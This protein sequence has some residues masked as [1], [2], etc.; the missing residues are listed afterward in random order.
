MNILMTTMGLQIGGAETHI[1]ELC[2]ALRKRGHTVTVAAADGVFRAE[3]EQNGVRCVILPLDRPAPA[4]MLSAFF[5]L[6]RL[7]RADHFDIVHA[8]ARLPA[9]LCR[10]ICRSVGIPLVTTAHFTFRLTPLRRH[11]SEWGAASLAVS[12][13]IKEYLIRNYGISPNRISLTVN[14]IDTE[15][16]HPSVRADA[17]L[18][19]FSLDPNCR[20]R[21]VYVSR[22]D[23]N[24]AQ[25]GEYLLD[26]AP[27]LL[28]AF[29]DL[30]ILIAGSGD[31]S[32]VFETRA[33]EINQSAGRAVVTLAG[34][35]T[36]IPQIVAAANVFL[37]VSRAALEAMAEEKPVV[38]A[39]PQGFLGIWDESKLDAAV[40]SNFCC[41]NGPYEASAVLQALTELLSAS[42]EEK[43]RIGASG[44]AMVLRHYTTVR[45]ADDAEALYRSVIV[46]A[47]KHADI[48]IS[49]YYGYRNNG[50]EF[51][52]SGILDKLHR[53]APDASVAVLSRHPERTA[54]QFDVKCIHRYHP[55]AVYRT[56]KHA[57][58]L[59]SGGGT[60]LTDIT[61]SRS[62]LYYTGILKLAK[63]LGCRTAIYES[64]VGPI[65]K[66]GNRK[67]ARAVLLAADSITLRDTQSLRE[68]KALGIDP[69][70]AVLSA[71]PAFMP[72]RSDPAWIL[73]LR[74]RIGIPEGTKFFAVALRT[75]AA[76]ISK[77]EGE[78]EKL[79]AVLSRKLRA[80]PVFLSMQPPHDDPINQSLAQKTGGIFLSDVSASDL[81]TILRD[82]E[83]LIG[84]R[85]HALIYAIL[86]GTVPIG[87]A[88]DPKITAIITDAGLPEPIRFDQELQADAVLAYTE[89]LLSDRDAVLEKL[90]AY[91]AEKT[92]LNEELDISRL[93]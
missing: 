18:K 27:A 49:G 29:P 41:L 48:V 58:L 31:L 66:P 55:I 34:A 4:K 3:L 63:R 25:A 16:F 62:L 46:P 71:D 40:S 82:S 72:I 76:G 79:L 87:L 42:E 14:G 70:K 26:S 90:R 10:P 74:T 53:L 77:T 15:K 12:C 1:V 92:R 60:L 67:A 20:H 69:E 38:L 88:C 65:R 75:P 78:L 86:A 11:F 84:M 8:H 91:A 51:I 56:L 37:G 44:Q 80:V 2:K 57:K 52:L 28:K 36:D 50:D 73:Y 6:K 9:F 47:K 85:L 33:A 81:I 59:I 22:L 39:G 89:G 17:V 61:S 64:G 21:I 5:G 35:R 83:L 7:I 24:A 32:A 54:R 19:E 13:G 68:L 45:M 30:E 93:L 43:A 23:Q